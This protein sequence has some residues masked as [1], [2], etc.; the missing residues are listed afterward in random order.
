[1]GGSRWHLPGWL[2]ARE[3]SRLFGGYVRRVSRPDESELQHETRHVRAKLRNQ[4]LANELGTR[5]VSFS[6]FK[7]SRRHAAQNWNVHDPLSQVNFCFVFDKTFIFLLVFIRGTRQKRTIISA[8][9]KTRKCAKR[10]KLSGKRLFS[11][12]EFFRILNSSG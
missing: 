5:R 12:C 9:K 4:Q 3:R 8:P 2:R 1:M 6:S 11:V 10:L 7:E